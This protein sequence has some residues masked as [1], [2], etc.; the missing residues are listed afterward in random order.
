VT[1][2]LKQ[3]IQKRQKAHKHPPRNPVPTAEDFCIYCGAPYAQTHEIFGGPNRQL[4]IEHKLQVRLCNF[5]HSKITDNKWPE[6]VKEL[7]RTGQAKF[8]RAHTRQE[9]MDIFKVGNY[10]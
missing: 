4:S 1:P 8:E 6:R 2:L 9:F 3:P 7:K 10:L 5:C